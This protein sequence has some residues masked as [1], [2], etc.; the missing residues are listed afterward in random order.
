[1]IILGREIGTRLIATAIFAA[2][3]LAL[4]LF[5]VSQCDKRRNQAAQTHLE[6]AQ[7]TA[8]QESSRDA[9][10]TVSG[11]G[12]R[13]AESADLTRE[14]EKEIRN[15]QGADE[16]VGAGVNAAGRRSLCRRAAYRDDPKCRVFD[17]PAR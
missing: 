3:V 2:F 6:R 4:L 13:E 11:A 7:G 9:I 5:G 1:M 16:R 14:N 17:A 10:N 8:A 12:E 15:A